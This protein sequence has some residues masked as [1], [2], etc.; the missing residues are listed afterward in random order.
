MNRAQ[1]I[2]ARFD[3]AEYRLCRHLNR[4]AGVAFAAIRILRLPAAWAMA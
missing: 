2:M 3:L 4:G 1:L